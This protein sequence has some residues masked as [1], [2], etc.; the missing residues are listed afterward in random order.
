MAMALCNFFQIGYRLDRLAPP[1]VMLALDP[2]GFALR[3][4]LSAFVLL[5]LDP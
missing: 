4:N 1:L 2:G 3:L 5:P